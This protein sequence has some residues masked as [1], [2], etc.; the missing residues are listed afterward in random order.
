MKYVLILFLSFNT[1]F[2]FAQQSEEIIAKHII[3]IG[4]EKIWNSLLSY[5]YYSKINNEVYTSRKTTYFDIKK[6]YREILQQSNS[7][8]KKTDTLHKLYTPKAAWESQWNE[9]GKIELIKLNEYLAQQKW[10]NLIHFSPFINYKKN[11]IKVNYQG[12]EEVL[13]I[14]Y[15]KFILIFN[16][17]KSEVVY[18]N[19]ETFLIDKRFIQVTDVDDY[20]YYS[21]YKTNKEGYVIPTRIETQ[22]GTEEIESIFINVPIEAKIFFVK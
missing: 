6:G 18:V 10:K 9:K 17:D 22:N 14:K 5:Q 4:G 21:D 19:P 7:R 12:I 2:L 1:T 15:H 16:D 20:A 8:E 13:D 11:G 3:A